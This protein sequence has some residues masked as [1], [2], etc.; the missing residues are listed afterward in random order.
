MV[1][2]M[3]VGSYRELFAAIASSSAGLTGL[4]FVAIS[5]GPGRTSRSSHRVIK[6]IS[7][8]ASLLAFSNGL[9]VSLFGLIPN[10]NVGYPAISLGVV[11]LFFTAASLRSLIGVPAVRRQRLRQLGLVCGLAATFGI[12]LVGGV[13]ALSTPHSRTGLD[14]VSNMLVAS[15]LVGVARAWELVGDRNTNLFSSIA[16]LT[17]HP[18]DGDDQVDDPNEPTTAPR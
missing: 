3:V 18:A 5:V 14:L 17:G 10:Q 2:A 9:T 16:V 8:S 15:L 7:A 1:S 6:E 11:G 4:L 13:E 12:E